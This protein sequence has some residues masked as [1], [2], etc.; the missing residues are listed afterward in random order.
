MEVEVLLAG[1]P[2]LQVQGDRHLG[3]LRRSFAEHGEFLEH[4][5][6]LGIV[7]DEVHHVG[8]GAF[9]IAAI[10]IEEL[11]HGD[12]AT[13]VA[14][15]HMTFGIEDGLA[16]LGDGRP[17][18]FGGGVGL[19][20]VHLA[21]DFLQKFGVAHEIFTNNFLDF[22]ALF[23]RKRLR[24]GDQGGPDGEHKGKKCNDDAPRVE[25]HGG[26]SRISIARIRIAFR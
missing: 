9:A 5:A 12:V 14:E 18:L 7:L 20:L 23:G 2:V 11:H 16:M 1:G 19:L 8:H 24:K 22:A 3:G 17:H 13:R 6:Q 25:C 10:V 15:D 21:D 26:P 4:D